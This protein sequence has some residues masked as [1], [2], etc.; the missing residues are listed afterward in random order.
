[1]KEYQNLIVGKSKTSVQQPH[2][3]RET[4]RERI[5]KTADLA[6]CAAQISA[7][8]RILIANPENNASF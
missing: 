7:R 6:G 2:E 1:M 3:Q 5:R 8:D 4:D